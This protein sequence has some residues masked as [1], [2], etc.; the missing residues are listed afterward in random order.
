MH[1]FRLL[2]KLRLAFRW[3][4]GSF[5]LKEQFGT[6]G[7]NAKLLYPLRIYSPQ[8]VFVGENVKLSSGLHILNAP[9]EKVIIGKYTVFAANVTIAP[10]NHVSTVT[11]PQFLLGASHV[12]DRSTDIIIDEDVWLGTGVTVLSGVHIGRGCI[13]GARSLVTKSLPPYSVAVGNPARI[14]KKNFSIEQILRHEMKLYTESE[15][16]TK[17]Q[18]EKNE[19]DYFKGLSV[20][21]TDSGLTEEA[22]AKI[23]EIKKALNYIEPFD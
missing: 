4:V 1:L 11:I 23:E 20:Y 21:G 18:L 2:K 9:N 17:E 5:P 16:F 19:E 22:L 12:N 10:N 6:C 7:K 8:S 15:R 14:V 3:L 13:V